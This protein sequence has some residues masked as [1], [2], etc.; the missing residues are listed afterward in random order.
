MGLQEAAGAELDDQVF[1]I[2]TGRSS[3][4]HAYQA[5]RVSVHAMSF[6]ARCDPDPSVP[7]PTNGSASEVHRFALHRAPDDNDLLL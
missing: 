7:F 1:S 2:C 6:R 5:T 3:D 4:G